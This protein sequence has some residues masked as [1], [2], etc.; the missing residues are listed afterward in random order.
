MHLLPQDGNV[1]KRCSKMKVEK[2]IRGE[3]IPPPQVCL[4]NVGKRSSQMKVQKNY[5]GVRACIYCHG[6]EILG[7]VVAK[8]K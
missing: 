5:S 1:G 6:V 3:R 4:G 2:F 7:D 8:W